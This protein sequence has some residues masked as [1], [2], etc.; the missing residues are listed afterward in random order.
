MTMSISSAPASAARRVSVSLT[1][2]YVW[3]DGKP[4]ATL[5]TLTPLPLSASRAAGIMAG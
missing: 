2:R 3:P 5:A 1:S 4:V